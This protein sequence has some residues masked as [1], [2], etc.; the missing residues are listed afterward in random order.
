MTR[1]P[2]SPQLPQAND[3]HRHR[4]NHRISREPHASPKTSTNHLPSTPK[5]STTNANQSRHTANNAETNQNVAQT[6]PALSAVRTTRRSSCASNSTE[7]NDIEISI[8]GPSAS[9]LSERNTTPPPSILTDISPPSISAT[10][11][12]DTATLP[13]SS[14]NPN[15]HAFRRTSIGNLDKGALASGKKEDVVADFGSSASRRRLPRARG[16]VGA[17]PAGPAAAPNGRTR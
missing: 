3:E 7:A 1:D 13:S 14:T 15:Y 11:Q 16:R 4:H 12:S 8:A 6:L 17:L 2:K 10:K 9:E 5:K